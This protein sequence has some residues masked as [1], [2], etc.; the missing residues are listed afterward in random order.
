[1][2]NHSFWPLPVV[3][4]HPNAKQD[5]LTINIRIARTK[6]RI[7]LYEATKN[8]RNASVNET[9]R[10]SIFGQQCFIPQQTKTAKNNRDRLNSDSELSS[11]PDKKKRKRKRKKNTK[12]SPSPSQS[13]SPSPP[14]KLEKLKTTDADEL[15]DC[16]RAFGYF[17]VIQAFET[18]RRLQQRS[19]KKKL[20]QAKMDT[21]VTFFDSNTFSQLTSDPIKSLV[22]DMIKMDLRLRK[23]EKELWGELIGK[24]LPFPRN[25]QFKHEKHARLEYAIRRF[26][27]NINTMRVQRCDVCNMVDVSR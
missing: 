27:V 22:H 7:Q 5:S 19:P 2:L 11:S 21:Q 10:A 26:D 15:A 16:A 14:I 13:P 12:T 1:M 20:K 24:L 8:A 18:I 25:K 6:Q 3:E 17:R 9:V 23:H 4:H